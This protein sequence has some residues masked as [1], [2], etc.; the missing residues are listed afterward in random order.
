M[1]GIGLWM[2]I[3]AVEWLR[4]RQI[5]SGNVPTVRGGHCPNLL[6][7]PPVNVKVWTVS[8]GVSD[9]SF[10]VVLERVS[11]MSPTPTP[12][13]TTPRL[14]CGLDA[15]SNKKR[16]SVSSDATSLLLTRF[17]KLKVLARLLLSD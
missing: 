4:R 2:V 15:C 7:P 16:S 5:G 17:H 10:K 11:T 1:G 3:G 6:N 9:S 12:Q 13:P 14:V 8:R